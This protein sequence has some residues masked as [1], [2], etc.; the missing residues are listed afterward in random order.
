MTGMSAA[1]RKAMFY[2]T[3]LLAVMGSVLIGVGK[4]EAEWVQQNHQWPPGNDLSS[5]VMPTAQTVIAVGGRS[6]V[7]STDG[8]AT[9]TV[10]DV[11][12]S[13]TYFDLLDVSCPDANTCTAVGYELMPDANS[14]AIIV[15]TIDGWATWTT[16][17]PSAAR[18]NGVS[19]PDAHGRGLGV[20]R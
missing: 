4:A 17:R 20:A 10:R 3:I 14:D 5:V 9:W 2:C 16:I 13:G 19:C 11:E 1:M 18:L 7:K 8:G 15:R 12:P 6:I